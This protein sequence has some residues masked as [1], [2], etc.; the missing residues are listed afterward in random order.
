MQDR[1][2]ITIIDENSIIRGNLQCNGHLKI[3]G[4]VTGNII[5]SGR[6][7]IGVNGF[8]EGSIIAQ[9]LEVMGEVIGN[10]LVK[11]LLTLKPTARILGDIQITYLIIEKGAKH[12]GGCKM[13]LDM[14]NAI[15]EYSTKEFRLLS[16]I[17]G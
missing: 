15:P 7:V 10:V 3:N 16:S 14:A 2:P 9:E 1:N 13:E 6:V 8:V 4:R 11:D 12:V 17:Q 5:T